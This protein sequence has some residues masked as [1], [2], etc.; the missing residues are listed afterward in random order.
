MT[1]GFDY[2]VTTPLLIGPTGAR[3]PEEVST[4][5]D[6]LAFWSQ[7]DLKELMDAYRKNL[8]AFRAGD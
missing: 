6:W 3:L 8:G 4:D 1:R 2:G 5:P 7:P